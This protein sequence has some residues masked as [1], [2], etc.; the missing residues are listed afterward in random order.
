MSDPDKLFSKSEDEGEMSQFGKITK[1]EDLPSEE[2]IFA[3]IQDAMLLIDK[4]V[5]LTKDPAKKVVKELVIPDY[6]LEAIDDNPEAQ[7]NFERFTSFAKKGICRLD[8]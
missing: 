6:F 3:L 7:E 2:Q 1:V 4:G 8:C 5:K